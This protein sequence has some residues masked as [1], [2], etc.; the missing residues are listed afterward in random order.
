MD[1]TQ[2]LQWCKDRAMEY[3]DMGDMKQAHASFLSDMGKHEETV[4]H[5]ALILGFQMLMGGYL[6]HPHEMKE[7]INGFN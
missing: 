6:D 2:H 7:W 5:P 3:V 4:R 1:R